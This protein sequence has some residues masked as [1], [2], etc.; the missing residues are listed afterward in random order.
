MR[1][2]FNYTVLS[3]RQTQTKA[4]DYQTAIIPP[5]GAEVLTQPYYKNIFFILLS[6]F[7]ASYL[8]RVSTS[9]NFRKTPT[10]EILKR[11]GK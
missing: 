1:H 11:S 7:P 5:S 4:D 2:S 9:L 8:L 10:K 3:G 6:V